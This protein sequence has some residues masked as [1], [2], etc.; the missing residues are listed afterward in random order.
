MGTIQRNNH[1]INIEGEY[2]DQSL[3]YL[4]SKIY[5]AIRKFEYQDIILDF[6]K[7]TY[8]SA[9]S[10]LATCAQVM[11]YRE[12]GIGINAIL[13]KQ[14]KLSKLFKNANW[15]YLLDPKRYECSTFRGY[16][17]VP[18][19]QYK[20]PKEQHEAVNRIVN[21]ILGA[22]PDMKRSSFAAFEW[23]INEITDNVLTHAESRIGGLVQVSTFKRT[24]KIVQYIVADSGKSIP[25]TL[26]ETHSEFSSDTDA[27][28]KAIRE[29]VTRDKSIGQGNG[30]FGSFQI[31]SRCKGEFKVDSGYGCLKYTEK[32]GLHIKS[33]T[34]PYDGT[35]VIASIDFTNPDLLEEALQFGGEKHSPIDYVEMKYESFDN[36]KLIFVMKDESSSFG[37]RPAG[38]PIRNKLANLCK[39]TTNHKIYIDFID[40]PLISSSFADEV[41]GKLFAEIGPLGFMKIFEFINISQTVRQLIDKAIAQR[42]AV[43]HDKT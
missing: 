39:M 32:S 34:V 25:K 6:S 4:L 37:S 38:T 35:V 19:T 12:A 23:S 29:G 28:D 41:F 1:M 3:H 10:M 11:E 31:C 15:A 22:V 14:Q 20:S 43:A 40:I 5:N 33:E 27:L 17:Q 9:S 42:M 30:L 2:T 13:P 24:K 21:A 18:A 16:T 26:R 36:E 7:C 8:T